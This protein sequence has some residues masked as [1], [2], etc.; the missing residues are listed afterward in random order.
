VDW[1]LLQRS[2]E[3]P[4]PEE[5]YRR[6][7]EAVDGLYGGDPVEGVFWHD[8]NR[9]AWGKRGPY[10][11]IEWA[12][13]GAASFSYARW[14]NDRSPLVVSLRVP[15]AMISDTPFTVIVHLENTGS[16][17]V[18]DVVVEPIEVPGVTFLNSGPIPVGTLRADTEASLSSPCVFLGSERDRSHVMIATRTKWT[19]ESPQNQ[20]VT[21]AYMKTISK[22]VLT[23]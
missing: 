6:L 23:K 10:R 21:F 2:T 1:E 11:R 5:F 8:L 18:H 4:G 3:P 22:N 7:I 17:D 9:G 12:V 19:P 13:T 14:K 15:D 16:A 20:Y